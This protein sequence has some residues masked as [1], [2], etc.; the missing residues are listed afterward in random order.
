M[1]SLWVLM[2]LRNFQQGG[3]IEGGVTPQIG[4]NVIVARGQ[5]RDS[6]S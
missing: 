4:I 6:K 1:M 3:E 2:S 5:E